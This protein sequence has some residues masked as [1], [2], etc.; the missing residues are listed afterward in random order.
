MR[1]AKINQPG[2]SKHDQIVRVVDRKMMSNMFV[3]SIRYKEFY[4]EPKELWIRE[5][6][7]VFAPEELN[8]EPLSVVKLYFEL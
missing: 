8:N 6:D 2:T 3:C 1:W 5:S 7:L 4:Y